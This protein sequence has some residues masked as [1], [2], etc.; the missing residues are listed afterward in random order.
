MSINEKLKTLMKK[1][2]I[3]GWLILIAILG[4][5]FLINYKLDD[6]KS[7]IEKSQIP[8]LSIVDK[9]Q[10]DRLC[11]NLTNQWDADDF[12]VYILQPNSNSKT[13]KELAITSLLTELPIRLPINNYDELEEKGSYFKGGDFSK[14]IHLPTKEHRKFLLVPIYKHNVIIAEMIVFYENDKLEENF[15]TKTLEA[16]AISML[17]I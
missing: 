17:L 12:V 16:Q 1:I 8:K 9:K 3:L 2:D 14:F 7:D 6:I 10:F 11:T 5:T 15:D 13:H 4:C